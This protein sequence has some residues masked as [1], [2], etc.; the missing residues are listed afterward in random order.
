MTSELVARALEEVLR[1]GGEFAEVFAEDRRAL[2]VRM[3]DGRIE[4]VTSGV[5][6]GVSIRLVRGG[7]SLFGYTESDDPEAVLALARRLAGGES[8]QT[9][10]APRVV[11][12]QGPGTESGVLRSPAVEIGLSPAG[13][14]AERAGELLHAIDETSR[15]RSGEVVQV[16]A[17]ATALEQRVAVANSRGVYA[18]DH[19]KRA[20][21]A[22]T[23]VARRAE[24]V[25]TGRETLA[26]SGVFDP[27]AVASVVALAENAADKAVVM[28][29]ARPSPTGRMPVVLA[30]GFGGVL[31]HEACGHGLEADYILKRT[32]VWEG[33]LGT[34][35]APSFL[36]AYDD[37]QGGGLWGTNLIDD[38]GWPTQRTAVIENGILASYLTDALRADKLGM[39]RT[40]NGRRES[41]RHLPYPRM[42]NTYFAPGDITAEELIADT[43]RAFYAKSL[44][45]GE[46]NPAT[47]DFVFGVSEGYLIENGRVGPA[48]RGA[49]LIGNG[50]EVLLGIDA[51]AAD[52]EVEPG[53]CGKEGQLVPVGT[54][55]P[56][57]RVRDM[58]IGGTDVGR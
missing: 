19:R 13:I 30:R 25:Q 32:S 1:R 58:T 14:S 26:L 46:V 47:G 24:V 5:D 15:S 2:N 10:A 9:P 38:E 33:K 37:G 23:V 31:F 17:G 35:V 56:T 21:I 22:V 44:S 12:P 29:G 40:G 41:F 8:A 52:L 54:G 6:R 53:F 34:R 45:G 27:P 57:V 11:L 50:L 4:A 55:Q 51:V 16:L 20:F 48:V 18:S 43:P 49:T 36:T 39:A 42:T 7:M 28:L 3:E